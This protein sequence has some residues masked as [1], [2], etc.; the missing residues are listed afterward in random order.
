MKMQTR[1]WFVKNKYLQIKGFNFFGNILFKKYISQNGIPDLI[2]CQSI[3]NAGFLGEKLFEK[4]NIPFIITE[5][6]SGF[7][8]K[9]QGF[10]KYYDSVIR[11]TNKAEK[12]FTVSLN[13]SEYLKKELSN[14]LEW[15]V[16]HNIVSDLFLN[17]DLKKPYSKNFIFLTINRLHRIKNISLLIESF[18]LFTEK[19]PNSELR[20]IGI[21]N[22]LKSL[23][24][25]LK[26]KLSF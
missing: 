7:K 22:E 6:N 26:K 9:T 5:H 14:N 19:F 12:C 3:F 16:H 25:L 2:H 13:Y 15:G 23:K 17:T 8:H 21:G 4:Y 18:F 11:I 20:I 24:L 1:S 10:Q